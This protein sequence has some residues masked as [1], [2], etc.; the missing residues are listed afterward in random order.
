[1]PSGNVSQT[2]ESGQG[3]LNGR[4]MLLEEAI[5]CRHSTRQFLPKSVPDEVLNTALKLAA[6]APSNSNTQAWR[7]YVVTGPALHR[8]KNALVAAA[9]S[10]AVPKIPPLPNEFQQWRSEVGNAV[11]GIGLGIPREDTVARRQAVMKN[12]EFFGA[13][14]GIIVCMSKK[15]PGSAAMSVGMHLQTLLLALTEQGVATCA[16]VSIAG[17]GD[18]VRA[19]VGV[20]DDLDILCGVSVGYEDVEAS[21][22]KIRI[23]R[24]KVEETT[25]FVRS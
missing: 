19:E 5:L 23:G 18:I 3:G 25:V 2:N 10:D 7:L 24:M 22:N 11:Y 9:S 8:L 1:M 6:Q 21:V 16:Q 12:F 14:V 15:L 4:R 13:P 20:R 17:Y